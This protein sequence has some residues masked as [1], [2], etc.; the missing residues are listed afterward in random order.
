MYP[1][2]TMPTSVCLSVSLSAVRKPVLNKNI[3]SEAEYFRCLRC[4][5]TSSLAY[6]MV[7]VY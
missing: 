4:Q 3:A 6:H 7:S 5:T 2:T 1:L